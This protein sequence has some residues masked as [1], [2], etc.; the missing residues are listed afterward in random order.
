MNRST[1]T[2]RE[3]TT[4]LQKAN[5]LHATVV[6]EAVTYSP[7]I[8]KMASLDIQG[9]LLTFPQNVCKYKQSTGYY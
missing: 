6:P 2:Q 4:T 7:I 8:H 1:I 5:V 9:R 3:S